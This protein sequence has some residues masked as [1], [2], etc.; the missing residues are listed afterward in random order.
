MYRAIGVVSVVVGLAV[1]SW[2]A[3][4]SKPS[5][6]LAQKVNQRVNFTGI[7]DART[8]LNDALEKL[9]KLYG[10]SFDIN[11]KAFDI[12]Q[13]KEVARTPIGETPIPEMKN[14]RLSRVLNTILR[15][16]PAH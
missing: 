5:S 12:D 15:R 8:T 11:G 2:A 14:A 9:S 6:S 4:E 3:P 1:L 10:V 13:L 16:V 7:D